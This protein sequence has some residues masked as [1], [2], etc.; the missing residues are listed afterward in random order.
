MCVIDP[1]FMIDLLHHE[2]Q[3][4]DGESAWEEAYFVGARLDDNEL[5]DAAA[6]DEQRRAQA[7]ARHVEATRSNLGLGHDIRA[8]LIQLS[9]AQLGAVR[10]IVCRLLVRHYGELIA[11]GAGRTDP[12]RQRPVGDTGRHEP[13][14][15]DAILA[16]ELE[17]A[18][19]DPDPLRGIAQL[20]ARLC[21]AFTLDPDGVTRTKTLG[22]E[23]M[24]RKLRD[25]LPGGESA[26]RAS[27]WQ[28]MRPMLSPALAL[29][30]RDAFVIEDESE[31][32]V[33]LAGCQAASSL[34]D[35][36]LDDLNRAAA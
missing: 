4:N 6:A 14:H 23:R 25:A 5:R 36:D 21:A 26:L 2:L 20:T 27:L 29:L 33:D 12:E 11:Y 32:T 13:R 30:H 18:I 7:R 35:L 16:D 1:A 3:D 17:R 10:D 8:G 19:E 28:L 24:A 15:P 22:S 31:T 9:D 34:D